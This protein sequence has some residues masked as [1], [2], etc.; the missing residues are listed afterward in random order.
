M[1]SKPVVKKVSPTAYLLALDSLSQLISC[2][3]AVPW[4]MQKKPRLFFIDINSSGSLT[5]FTSTS[6]KT[7]EP[8]LPTTKLP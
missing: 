1:P 2:G 5:S 8:V 3:A 6:S 7:V 4:A